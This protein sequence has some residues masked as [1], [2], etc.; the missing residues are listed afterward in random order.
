MTLA[1]NIAALR[2]L[3]RMERLAKAHKLRGISGQVAFEQEL[4]EHDRTL[5]VDC[6]LDLADMLEEGE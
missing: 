1:T 2:A 6:L 4:S 5:I 3:P